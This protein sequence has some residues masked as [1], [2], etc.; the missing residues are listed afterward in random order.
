MDASPVVDLAAATDGTRLLL[1]ALGTGA[2]EPARFGIPRLECTHGAQ[3]GRLW[4]L[5]AYPF[6]I[7]RAPSNRVVLHDGR[8]SRHHATVVERHGV[9]YLEP[10]GGAEVTVDG[11]RVRSAIRLLHDSVIELGDTSL[12]FR[13]ER[14]IPER[15][16]V[17]APSTA[18]G[19]ALPAPPLAHEVAAGSE[20][21]AAHEAEAVPTRGRPA[22]LL[23]AAAGLCSL[24]AAVLAT[25]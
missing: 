9:A 24:A 16:G 17:A 19:A 14:R 6:S 10:L 22:A 7:G 11:R 2:V 25:G 12:L 1:H 23:L 18:C 8:V 20:L 3:A 15:A 5:D 4:G 13:D 21:P